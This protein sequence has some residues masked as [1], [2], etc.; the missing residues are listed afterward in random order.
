M[1]HVKSEMQSIIATV[2]WAF[3]LFYPWNFQTR[4]DG[5]PDFYLLP[6]FGELEFEFAP[7]GGGDPTVQARVLNGRN[8]DV[9]IEKTYKLPDL[10]SAPILSTSVDS[11]CR[12]HRGQSTAI[13]RTLGWA[14]T[15]CVAIA[16]LALKPLVVAFPLWSFV[17]WLRP[18]PSQD[19]QETTHKTRGTNKR[20]K[21]KPE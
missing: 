12:P 21:A 8:G 2:F 20:N 6:N 14:M 7:P 19:Q 15:A 18:R 10:D 13:W 9:V 1:G 11:Q 5:K 16:L 3:Q 4:T 17:R